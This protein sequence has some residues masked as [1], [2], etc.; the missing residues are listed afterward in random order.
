MLDA[1]CPPDILFKFS[2]PKLKTSLMQNEVFRDLLVVELASV[3]AGPAVGMF[4]AELGARVIK[5]E[6]ARTGGDVTRRWKVPEENPEAPDS[7]YYQSVNWGKE[8]R[9]LD[10]NTE[11]AKEEVHRLV[12]KADIVISNFKSRS[13]QRMGMDYETLSEIN[14]QLIYA[15]LSAFGEEEERSAFDVVL[16]AESGFMYMTGEPGREPVRMP[17]AL[18]DI[19]AA[20]QLKEGIL[21]ALLQRERAG[22]GSYVSTSLFE[23]ALASLA[24]QATNW[25]IAGHIPQRRGSQHPNIAPYGDIF[26]TKDQ[27]QVVVAVGTEK[28]FQQLC[29]ALNLPHLNEEER[30]RSNALRVQQ[31]EDLLD[32]LRP[33]FQSMDRDE[34]MSLL[35]K[36][37]VPAGS[38]RDMQEVF[39]QPAARQMLLENQRPEGE[40]ARRV[41]TA[42]FKLKSRKD[43]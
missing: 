12:E 1:G 15:H 34:L 36:N 26:Y 17:V 4:F 28:Q 6:N 23:S 31:R 38:I 14:P 29:I 21:L 11:P 40:T 3:L 42:A 25:L 43:N 13:A 8:V 33:G 2:Y 27:K 37:G 41:R 39:E 24:N 7:A 30:F 19:L 5:I 18:I 32:A 9:L 22:K 20:H 35:K 16:Q 10:L